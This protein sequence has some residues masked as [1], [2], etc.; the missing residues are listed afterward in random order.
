[1][2]FEDETDESFEYLFK[3][4]EKCTY[5]AKFVFTKL[6]IGQHI[7]VILLAV[8]SVVISLISSGRIVVDKLYLP[9]KI[10]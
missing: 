4:N 5:L 10:M 8:L 9:Y 3:A 1:M 6:A 2:L 7:P